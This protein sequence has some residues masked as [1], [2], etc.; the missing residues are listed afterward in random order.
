MNINP[1][2]VSLVFLLANIVIILAILGLNRRS[3]SRPP[4]TAPPAEKPPLVRPLEAR[5]I[6]GWEFEYARFTASEAMSDRHTM[7][8]FYL[9]AFGVIATGVLAILSRE[10][11]LPQSIGTLLLWI[12]CAVGWLY[13][14]K[15]I[16][17]RQAWHDSAQAMNQIKEFYIQHDGHFDP[18][19]LRP[20]FRWQAH[21]LPPPDKAWTVF[22]Y[23]ALLIALLDS[24]AYVMGAALLDYNFSPE[25]PI[26]HL[27][28]YL[29]FGFGFLA[30]HIWIYFAF[31][32]KD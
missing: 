21:T 11:D 31:L 27:G 7:V 9:L 12:L 20:A 13:F 15:I 10:A 28:L 6:L 17:L 3:G 24:M 22:F 29:L 4:P 18:D 19:E 8:N 23:S 14:L 30:F 25:I 5:D 16:R 2:A 32:R 1:V 26:I